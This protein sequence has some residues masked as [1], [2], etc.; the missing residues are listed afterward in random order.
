MTTQAADFQQFIAR[1]ADI[2]LAYVNGDAAPLGAIVTRR[3]PAHFFGPNGGHAD[4]VEAVAKDFRDGAAHFEPGGDSRV[5]VL[6]AAA[7]GDLGYWA[8]LQHAHV[9][10]QGKPGLVPMHLRVTE[11]FRREEGGWKLV[12]RHADMLAEPQAKPAGR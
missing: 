5:E 1:R 8:G 3:E 10:V 12:H 6:Q 9:R 7:S 4:G 11:I 2:G